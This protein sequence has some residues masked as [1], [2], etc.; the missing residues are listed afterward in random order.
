M[1]LG[2][3]EKCHCGSSRKYKDCHLDA[4][5]LAQR[6]TGSGETLFHD[7]PTMRMALAA[8]GPGFADEVRMPAER[9]NRAFC[10]EIGDGLEGPAAAE[11]LSGYLERVE[12]EIARIAGQHSRGYWMHVTR[13]LPPTPL[14]ECSDWTVLLYR[15]VLTLAVIKHGRPAVLAEEFTTIETPAG[16]QQVPR[17]F[18]HDEVV[19]TFALEYLA[20]EYT[21]ATQAYRRVGKGARLLVREEDF[22]AVAE[23]EL[24][25]LIQDLDRRV[26]EFGELTGKYG[27][28]TDR[29]F[30]LDVD[31]GEDTPL[32]VLATRP[33]TLRVDPSKAM[34]SRGVILPGPSNFLA[35]PVVI[36][37]YSETLSTLSSEVEQA[38]GAP[39]DVLLGVLWALSM[40]LLRF[41]ERTPAVEVQLLKTGYLISMRED[42]DR[43]ADTLSRWVGGLLEHLGHTEQ[44]HEQALAA[45]E[46]GIDALSWSE[47]EIASISL[48]DR[49][50]FNL[51]L[52]AGAFRVIDYS[53]LSALFADIFRQIGFL[54]GES[55]NIKAAN[56]ETAVVARAGAE[57]F[58]PW[59]QTAELRH[60]DGEQR[61][62]DAGFV[63]GDVLY[64]VECKAYAQNPRIDRGDWT[65]RLSRQ[66]QLLCYLEQARTLAEFISAERS[67]SNYELH[68]QVARVEHLLCTPGVEFI[69]SSEE[70]LWLT[71]E[72]PRI[73]SVAELMIVLKAA[74]GE[75]S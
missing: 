15:R 55:G 26:G 63:A 69:W 28:L 20:F 37:G 10:Q 3:N 35:H 9:L 16:R 31:A 27:A 17:V 36:D 38:L 5:R 53:A 11:A 6:K 4:D 33:N 72:I 2:R 58:E 44:S 42:R 56:F 24:E 59:K 48:W 19:E 29:E 13:R 50:P 68:D 67:G 60:H 30:P 43:L 39:P 54:S 47:Q 61:E 23:E 32:A 21:T 8:Q 66:E 12:G 14:C 45:T 74:A 65:A 52:D 57:G 70:R 73:C 7:L 41:I 46:A 40:Y 1:S 75:P 34:I 51:I 71:E 25:D 18:D 49:L 64:V 22:A 62:I